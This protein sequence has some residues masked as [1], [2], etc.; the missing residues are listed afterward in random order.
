MELFFCL[1]IN[2]VASS[3]VRSPADGFVTASIVFIGLYFLTP[4]FSYIPS[5]ILPS[6]IIVSM[7]DLIARYT[8]FIEFWNVSLSDF[9]VFIIALVGTLFFNIEDGLFASALL[10]LAILI[11]RIARP[12]VSTLGKLSTG[13]GHFVR[14]ENQDLKATLPPPGIFVFRIEESL[15]Y[16]NANYVS[17]KIMSFVKKYTAFGGITQSNGDKLWCEE[18]YSKSNHEIT[19]EP[20]LENGEISIQS[21]STISS[22]YDNFDLYPSTRSTALPILK[23][24]I[25]DFSAVN[26]FD[27]TGNN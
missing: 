2:N 4:A 5:A 9:I 14:L 23:A 17:E 10:S 13:A 15:T 25:F 16:P 21:P 6:I 20:Y 11:F 3:G 12:Y 1:L 19:K 8:T 24:V 27:A 7:T 18:D 22:I 26:A